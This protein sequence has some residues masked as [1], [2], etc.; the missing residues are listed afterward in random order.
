LLAGGQ[1]IAFVFNL[2]R[3]V[4]GDQGSWRHLFDGPWSPP[5]PVAVLLLLHAVGLTAAVV[6]LV[7]FSRADDSEVTTGAHREVA[8]SR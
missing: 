7:R 4:V 2:R 8:A 6:L 5:V 1:L 3:Y